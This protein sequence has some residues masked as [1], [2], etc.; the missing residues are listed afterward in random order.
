MYKLRTNNQN[1]KDGHLRGLQLS[2]VEVKLNEV[3]SLKII[4]GSIKRNWKNKD[5]NKI[6]ESQIKNP[7]WRK[8]NEENTSDTFNRLIFILIVLA[9]WVSNFKW[10]NEEL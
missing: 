8:L 9:D 5:S 10:M 4:M 1:E 6:C 2:F 3:K 7:K